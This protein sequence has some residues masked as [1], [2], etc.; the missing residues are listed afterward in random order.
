[1]NLPFAK[2]VP[3]LSLDRAFDY[4]IPEPLQRDVVLGSKVRVPF[5]PREITGYV[6]ELRAQSEIEKLKDISAVIGQGAFV[7]P[8]IIELA[9]WISLYYCAPLGAALQTVLPQAVRGGQTR[10]KERLWV[11]PLPVK[12]PDFGRAKSQKNA[13]EFLQENGGGWLHELCV[14]TATTAAI[15]RSLEQKNLVAISPERQ[16]RDPHAALDGD[17]S[18]PLVFNDEQ[19]AAYDA[20]LEEMAKPKPQ[21]ILLHGVTGSGKTEVYLQAIARVLEAGKSALVLVPEIALTPQTV[22]RFRRRFAG[23]KAGVAVLHSHLSQGERHDQWHQIREGRAK[24]VIGARSAVFAPLVRLGLIVVDEEQENSYKQE[25]SP[26]YH[27][28]DVAVMRGHMEGVA[29]MLGSATPSLESYQNA[30]DKKYRLC[31][32]TRRVEVQNMPTTHILDLRQELK[33]VKTPTLLAPRLV[34]AVNKRIDAG[35]QTI[36]FL[37]R[38]GYATSLQCPQCGHV[39]ECPRCSVSLTYHRKA[40]KLCCHLCDFSITAPNVCPKCAFDQYKQ[41]GVGTEKIEESVERAFP[42]ARIMRMDSDTMRGKH[43]YDEALSKFAAG[44]TD[45]LVGTQM[46]AKGLHFPKVTCVG[47]VH[48][49]LALQLPDFR[50]AERVFQ[51]LMQ[52]S[53]RSGRGDVHGEVYVQTRTPFH[54]AI[55]FARHHDYDGFAEQELE[56]RKVLNYPPYQRA[57]L[58][59]WRGR[60]EEKTLYVAEQ[61]AK[62]ITELAGKDAL[63]TGPSPAPIAKINEQ[64]RFHLFLRAAKLLPVTRALRPLLLE[65]QWPDDIKVTVDVDPMNLL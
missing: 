64:Y 6:V 21:P 19:K 4:R 10:F 47:V 53:G 16:E 46:I 36:I 8:T 45:I 15:W 27:A 38:R 49:D 30:L 32:L 33:N 18:E 60:S 50:A 28:R 37:N 11:E 20:V 29:V 9:Q 62:K 14:A 54:P 63:I 51:L 61:T 7:P 1:M 39:E 59:T 24:I 58:I 56:F 65:A 57:I 43:A 42:N 31:S 35:E 41:R 23:Q 26:H 52:V 34:E 5:G 25:E 17:M 44:E 12:E 3:E 55:Q 13:W 2:V 40:N 22:D 48:A